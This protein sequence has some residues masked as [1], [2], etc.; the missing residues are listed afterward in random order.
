MKGVIIKPAVFVLVRRKN[1][2]L[3][4]LR[5]NTGW[6]DDYY[7][8]PSGHAEAGERLSDAA[9]REALE[10]TGVVVDPAKLKHAHTM[11]RYSSD[12]KLWVDVYF[13]ADEWSGEPFN[14][15]PHKHAGIEW[16]IAL[17]LPRAKIVTP[18]VKA[19][20][21]IAAGQTYSEWGWEKPQERG[22]KL[23]K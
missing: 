4:V 23:S 7:A 1:K 20:A 5:S 9:A 15:E 13:E 12:G 16:F 10:E 2:L 11:Y 21:S 19:L 3:F 8:L 6:M 18:Q 17:D 22:T 14:A